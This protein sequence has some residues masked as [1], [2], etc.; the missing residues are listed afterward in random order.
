MISR[1]K[2][3]DWLVSRPIAHRGLHNGKLTPENSMNAFEAAAL[4]GHPIELDV[5]LLSDGGIAVYHDRSLE[6]ICGADKLIK[7]ETSGSIKNYR[8]YDTDQKIPLFTEALELIAGRVPILIEI[9]NFNWPGKPEENIVKILRGY[10]GDYA[11]Q[12][13]NPFTPR[14]FQKNAPDIIRG[15]L[16][17]GID[18]HDVEWYRVQAMKYL[19]VIGISLPDFIGYDIDS[20]PNFPTRIARKLGYPLL[21]WTVRNAEQRRRAGEHCDNFIF[22]NISL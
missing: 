8:L 6:R 10:K 13:F 20:I 4:A 17:T 1:R 11:I 21:T 7:H 9:K 12:S 15:Q 5:H 22:E 19:L 14:W 16:A 18:Y 2:I 3:P